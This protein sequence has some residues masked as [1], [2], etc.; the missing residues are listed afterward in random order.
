LDI[1][2]AKQMLNWQPKLNSSQA[3]EWTIDWYKQQTDEVHNYTLQQ[4]KNFLQ[5]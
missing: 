1:T 3:I 4:I 5:L 2:K